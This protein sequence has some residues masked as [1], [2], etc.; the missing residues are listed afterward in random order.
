[1]MA[2]WGGTRKTAL[3]FG[4]FMICGALVGVFAGDALAGGYLHLLTG[5]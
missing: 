5:A 4:P 3:P 1:V 2:L